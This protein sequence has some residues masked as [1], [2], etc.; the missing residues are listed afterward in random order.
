MK[1]II[2][3]GFRRSG[4]RGETM[5]EVV[6]AFLLLSILL[7]MFSQGMVS[8]TKA[9]VQATKNRNSADKAMKALQE[10]LA[11]GVNKGSGRTDDAIPVGDGDKVDIVPYIYSENG[12]TYVVYRIYE[13]EG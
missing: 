4:K 12:Y 10:E 2:K 6:V 3:K 5:V 7:V 13:E 9:E 8:T 11:A 1:I